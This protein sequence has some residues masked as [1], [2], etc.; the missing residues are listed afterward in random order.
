MGHT[1]TTPL[2]R[3]GL[4]SGRVLTLAA[5]ALAAMFAVVLA[6]WASPAA[7]ASTIATSPSD[8]ETQVI[9]AV[10][11]SRASEDL[12][13]LTW[14]DDLT[15]VAR[16]HAIAM[17]ADRHLHH[18]PALGDDVDG[19]IKVGENVG[20]SPSVEAVHAAFL[21]SPSHAANILDPTFTEIGIGVHVQDGTLW[22]TQI[23]RQP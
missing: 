4:T 11:G 12:A 17:A 22:V 23:F 14:T 21:D 3:R 18:N 6:T 19:W 1:I 5:V 10:N 9:D 16:D 15:I 8:L 13:P 20:R 2:P 7:S